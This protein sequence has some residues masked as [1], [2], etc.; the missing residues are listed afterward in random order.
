MKTL[1]YL[2]LLMLSHCVPSAGAPARSSAGDSGATSSGANLAART[3]DEEPEMLCR[4]E[5]PTGSNISRGVCEPK[6]KANTRTAQD[7][8]QME[9]MQR[10]SNTITH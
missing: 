7:Q 2:A 3:A 5:R 9:R 10:G 1:P 8:L 4:R 6:N